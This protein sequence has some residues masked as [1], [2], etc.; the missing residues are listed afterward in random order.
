MTRAR[1]AAAA[2]V[3][4]AVALAGVACSSKTKT[5]TEG[6]KARSTNLSGAPA[7]AL[8]TTVKD[9]KVGL[10]VSSAGPGADLKDMAAG[11]YI[12]AFRLNEAKTGNSHVELAVQDDNG[13]PD[14]AT[15]AVNNLVD[16][17]VIGIVYASTGEQLLAGAATAAEK[18]VAVVYPY[19]DDHRIV[20]Q[21]A[22]S[23]LAS[24]TIEQVA[25]KLAD[26]TKDAGKIALLRQ[27]G[28]YGDAG[29]AA[30][31]ADGLSF[32]S[33]T[34]ITA[35]DPISA[36]GIVAGA[37]DAVIVFADAATSLAAADALSTAGYSGALLFGDRAAVPAFGHGV[38][39]SLA[40]AVNDG[41]LSVGT[42]AGPDLP[43]AAADAFYLAR[44]KAVSSG[45]VSADLTFADFRSHDAVLAL[46]HAAE[47]KADRADVLDAIKNVATDAVTGTV[48][49]PDDFS[50]Q[51]AF[52]DKNVALLTYSS[53]NDGGG[54]YPTDATAGGHWIAVAG[55]YTP[56]AALAGLDNPYGG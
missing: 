7:I 8:Q 35:T 30:L 11:A 33:D 52:N 14:G 25:S 56:P 54:R 23:Y 28:S 15:A 47:A 18:G 26:K 21:G 49:A 17:G 20:D 55:S 3:C 38:A 50:Q 2:A 40:P 37:P 44:D 53:L 51:L 6:E 12:A 27:A 1:K 16:Q 46:V 29:K 34:P 42:W 41:A 32:V 43:T 10:I 22:T 36:T 9:A 24:P 19:A 48:G 39:G 45:A 5:N 31:V 4:V 13:T